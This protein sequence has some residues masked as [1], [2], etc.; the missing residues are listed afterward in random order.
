MIQLPDS[1]TQTA[2]DFDWREALQWDTILRVAI[3]I[4]IALIA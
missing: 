1:A 3:V 2:P 4:I